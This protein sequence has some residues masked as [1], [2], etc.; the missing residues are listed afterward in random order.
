[1]S[2]PFVLAQISDT[3]VRADDHAPGEKLR[4]ALQGAR[5]Y[6]ADA[7]VL[8]GDLVNDGKSEEYEALAAVLADPPAPLFLMAGN[9]DDGARLRDAFP[10]HRYL[11]RR[12]HL[13]YA[14]DDFPVR[15]VV[16]DQTVAGEVHGEV[17]PELAAWLDETLA[18]APL[19]PTLLALHHPPFATFDRLFD[20]LCLRNPET[21]ERIVARHKQVRRVICGHMHRVSIGQIAHAPAI[22]AP[23]TS[24]IYGLATLEEHTLAPKTA[25]QPGWMLH[26]W[27][28]EAGF[29][30]HFMGL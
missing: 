9:H 18:A 12:G 1:M 7:I 10:T 28:E 22:C 23:S 5:R 24:W 3:H 29:A 19:K 30:S 16:L 8:T 2:R 15:L 21:L 13:S 11:P 26:I 6:A 14:I 4:R 25:E 27:T 17:T 20:T